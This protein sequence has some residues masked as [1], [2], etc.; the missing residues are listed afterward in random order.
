MLRSCGAKHRRSQQEAGSTGILLAEEETV[1][2]WNLPALKL[3]LL[4]RRSVNLAHPY[5][6]SHSVLFNSS[7]DVKL[8]VG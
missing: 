6:F 1:G 8:A 4:H 7:A 2:T 3:S 5:G